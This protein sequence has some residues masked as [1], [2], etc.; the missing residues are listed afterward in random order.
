MLYYL[1]GFQEDDYGYFKQFE[2]TQLIIGIIFGK[3]T[4]FFA[5]AP[6]VFT[7]IYT[8]IHSYLEYGKENKNN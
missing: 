3:Y 6:F 1:Y 2:K 5:I 7:A 8:I 4:I